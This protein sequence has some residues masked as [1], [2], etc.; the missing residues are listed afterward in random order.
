MVVGDVMLD[1]YC[2]GDVSRIS[3]EAPV[4]VVALMTTTHSPG[5]AANVAAN[6][7]GLGA[8]P[9]LIGITGGDAESALLPDVLRA[10]NIKKYSLS[11]I[12]GRQ[13]SLKTRIV[14]GSQHVVRLDHESVEPI[15]Q[16]EAAPV[17]ANLEKALDTADVIIISDYGKGLLS[18]H[19][20]E[21]I[22]SKARRRKKV[23]I[24]DPKG[25]D[26]NKYAGA[27]MITPNEREA[28]EA[29]HIEPHRQDLLDKAGKLLL[30][31][32]S[33][34]ALLVT[35]GAKGMTLLQAGQHAVHLKASARQV[36]DVTGA[37]D[38]VIASLAVA[39]GAG[40][41]Y[42]KAAEFANFAAGL[43]VEQVGT[44]AISRELLTGA[45]D[46]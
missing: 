44:T 43:V 31:R 3:P 39:I 5:G 40:L 25:K 4:P 2:W 22:I 12:R 46:S 32:L 28:A 11:K 37:G 1:R 15:T 41:D 7:A 42:V 20:L 35:Q 26:F 6:I 8:K 14:A 36:F 34:D 23:V 16:K 19:V 10:A 24:V 33:L 29:C 18:E 17:I 13:T 27:K 30:E 21:K 9:H 45:L 38:T